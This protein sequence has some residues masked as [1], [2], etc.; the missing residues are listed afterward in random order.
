MAVGVKCNVPVSMVGRFVT[1]RLVGILRERVFENGHGGFQVILLQNIGN[2][3]LVPSGFGCCIKTW[4]RR[5]HDGL[6]VMLKLVQDPLAK[7]VSV[8]D[9]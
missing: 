2:A 7:M 4:S 5:H 6:A 8:F 3:D 1:G 9:R